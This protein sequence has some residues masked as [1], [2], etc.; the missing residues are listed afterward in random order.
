MTDFMGNHI[1]LGKIPCGLKALSHLLEKAH[2]Q[3]HFLVGRAV[4]RAAGRRGEA[5]RRVDL[6]TE[7]H[8]CRVFISATGLLKDLTPGV[9]GIAQHGTH[10]LGLLIVGRRC[11]TG[12]LRD[13]RR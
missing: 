4:K 12:L 5:T 1:R 11:M 6:A 2:V 7:Q 9:F 3:V 10:E 8:Q 13:L